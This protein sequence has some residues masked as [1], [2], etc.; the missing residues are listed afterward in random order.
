MM[1]LISSNEVVDVETV[2][3]VMRNKINYKE[4]GILDTESTSIYFRCHTRNKQRLFLH[5]ALIC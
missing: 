4:L 5:T 3:F 1:C 2:V